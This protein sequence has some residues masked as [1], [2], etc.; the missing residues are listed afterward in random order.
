VL[1]GFGVPGVVVASASVSALQGIA[2]T[3]AA[4]DTARRRWGA[5]WF[6]SSLSLLRGSRRRIA[7]FLI[8]SN[9]T[10]LVGLVVK[11]LDVIS[12]GYLRGPGDAGIYSLAR[13]IS[14][15][16]AE[17]VV[18]LQT[19]LYPR[20]ARALADHQ[21]SWRRT[22][23]QVALKGGLP[24]GIPVL[25][26]VPLAGPAIEILFGADYLPA[27]GASEWLLASSAVWL[28]L[29]W[30]RPAYLSGG[31]IRLWFCGYVV[32][33]AVFLALLTPVIT[34]YGA[35]GLAVLNGGLTMGFHAAMLAVFAAV[36][37]VDSRGQRDYSGS[38][39]R[40]PLSPDPE[41]R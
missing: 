22:V 1:A 37:R 26:A 23:W 10:V 16:I 25:L 34:R 11:Q 9:A 29:F 38:T 31:R 24:L 39:V 15:A 41:K 13:K 33:A 19:V 27:V 40:V 2:F 4:H 14:T 3:V 17:L 28:M 32:Y 6:G 36:G 18:P 20:L 7:G 5:S 30:L 35:L 21:R 12:L 8:Y